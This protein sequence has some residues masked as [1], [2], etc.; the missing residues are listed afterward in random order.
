MLRLLGEVS[1]GET[2]LGPPK[3]RCLLAALA[4]DAGQVVP[5]D[6]LLD[7]VW[8][9]DVPR[10]GRET[11]HS[12]LSRLRQALAG[13]EVGIAR[14]SGGYV[15]RGPVDLHRSRELCA[16][17]RAESP[18]EAA[19]LFAEAL[20]LWRGEPLAGLSGEWAAEERDRLAQERLA[21]LHDHVDARLRLG[22]GAQLVAELAALAAEHPL[23]ERVAGQYLTA[24]HQA[25]RTADALEHYRLVRERLVA[26]LGADPGAA[27]Q[28]LHTQ[29]L[30]GAPK[31][32]RAVPRQLPGTPTPF[33]GRR[34]ELDRLDAAVA[35][36]TGA[37]VISA[38]AGAGG[39]G[40]T[41]LALH[42]AHER[43]D[44]F[45]DGQLFV[46]LLGFT[47]DNAPLD[48]ATVLRGFLDALGVAAEQIPAEPHA[49]EALFRSLVADRRMLVLL[50]NAATADQVVPLLPGGHACTVLVTSRR[51]LSTLIARHGAGH[52]DLTVLGEAESRTLLEHRLGAARVAAEPNAVTA[53]LDWCRGFPLALGLLAGRALTNP[54]LS[55]TGLAAELREFGVDALDDDDPLASLP[56]VMVSSHRALSEDQQRVF[57]LLAIAPG[58]DIGLPAAAS[59]AGLT[60]AA[61]TR[62]LRELQLA[63]LLF[64]DSRGRYA[65]HDLIRAY[66]ATTEVHD[67]TAVLRV[68]D[69]YL[70]TARTAAY[71]VDPHQSRV[72]LGPPATGALPVEFPDSA[73]AV[74][75][76]DSEYA[77]L[78]ALLHQ[79]AA[80]R[81]HE[82]VWQIAWTQRIY[83][84]RRGT[85]QE[86][87]EMW[88]LAAESSRHLPDVR[89][90]VRAHLRLGRAHVRLDQFDEAAD[91]LHRALAQAQEH[92]LVTQMNA[93]FDLAWMWERRGEEHRALDH[94]RQALTIARDH[95]ENL[96]GEALNLVGWHAART[97]DY[98]MARSHCEEALEIHRANDYPLGIATTVD[99]LGYVDHFTGR[100]RE[101]IA[102][103]RQSITMLRELGYHAEVIADVFEH[104][105]R[106]HAALGERKQAH[107]AWTEA[108]ELYLRLDRTA[109]AERMSELLEHLG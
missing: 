96:V 68:T 38:I 85:Y 75:W 26:E 84:H 61:T 43:S 58:P 28:D 17:G 107:A 51:V 77:C 41:W 47:P 12:Y 63:S 100:H 57:G 35:G 11:L 103:H 62:V 105:G 52:L 29:L 83:V 60:P 6:R 70:H 78:Q 67:E 80:E 2:D 53:L 46:D 54:G 40:K 25:G 39:I 73:A 3:Q 94:A 31:A 1:A 34:A 98:D 99:S 8:G 95:D 102:R 19:R 59:L 48:P 91:T 21:V 44:R 10:R 13:G 33:V 5:V 56:A 45:P 79:A 81:R 72:E 69:F 93:H 74:A 64:Q 14:R 90:R 4:V 9:N 104:L 16:A 106:P 55:L 24:L 22:H 71:L 87:L 109:D 42:W 76:L 37:V 15:L 101:A 18:A 36:S 30:A 27:L 82:V 32:S 86:D 23:D 97:G 7:R 65:M 66:A 50:D 108:R 89:N 49:R 92:G 88:R 20:E